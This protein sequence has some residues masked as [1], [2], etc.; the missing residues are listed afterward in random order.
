METN[1]T[2]IDLENYT[3]PK[4]IKYL[5]GRALGEK[6]RKASN[7][8]ELEDKFEYIIIIMP[9]NVTAINPSYFLGLFGDSVRKCLT[10]ERFLNK[11]IFEFNSDEL[12]QKTILKNMKK[13]IDR[14][15]R[16]VR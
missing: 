15:L 7:L 1:K 16:N 11:F 12:V 6:V 14:A 9:I 4:T 2:I 13:S 3:S 10:E 5:S 8:N